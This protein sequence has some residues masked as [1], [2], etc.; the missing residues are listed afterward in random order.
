MLEVA[1]PSEHHNQVMLVGS[2]DNFLVLHRATRLNNSNDAGLSSGFNA[3]REREERVRALNSFE[4]LILAARLKGKGWMRRTKTE[5]L[6]RS[7]ARF[8]ASQT[9]STRLG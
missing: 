6:A 2:I 3:V 9:E 4:Q 7:P 5:F 8:A 1:L